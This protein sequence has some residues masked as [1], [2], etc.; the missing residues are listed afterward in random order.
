MIVK[1]FRFLTNSARPFFVV[2]SLPE[3]WT[4]TFLGWQISRS[5]LLNWVK[6]EVEK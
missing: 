5:A 2:A 4:E 3:R 1:P 6:M